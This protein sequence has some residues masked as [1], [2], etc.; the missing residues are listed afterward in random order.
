MGNTVTRPPEAS[1]QPS[2]PAT[3]AGHYSAG[4]FDSNFESMFASE[5][6]PK[7]DAGLTDLMRQYSQMP[8]NFAT[9][10]LR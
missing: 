6:S 10:S 5:Q 9:S 7:N 2:G 8:F 3:A 1:V 4:I